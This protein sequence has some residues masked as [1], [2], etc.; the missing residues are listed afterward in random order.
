[1]FAHA[2]A[3]GVPID[4]DTITLNTSRMSKLDRISVHGFGPV[5]GLD[6]TVRWNDSVHDSVAFRATSSDTHYNNPPA[7]VM[8]VDD[9]GADVGRFMRA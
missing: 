8:L 2:A 7:N 5:E 3:L 6:R 4:P 1:M 9:S